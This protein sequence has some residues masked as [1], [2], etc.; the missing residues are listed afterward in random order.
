M[1]SKMLIQLFLPI[2]K[3]FEYKALTMNEKEALT[4][5]TQ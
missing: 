1:C 4:N 2:K 5:E 3:G